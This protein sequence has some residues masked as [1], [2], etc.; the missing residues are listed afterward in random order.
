MVK[1]WPIF[2]MTSRP[3]N[4]VLLLR[5]VP[6]DANVTGQNAINRPLL[7]CLDLVIGEQHVCDERLGWPAEQM[8]VNSLP[9]EDIRDIEPGLEPAP[10]DQDS[11]VLI[12]WQL[13]LK[14][15]KSG[16]TPAKFYIWMLHDCSIRPN[17]RIGSN[18]KSTIKSIQ[19]WRVNFV[20]HK[21]IA[22][23]KIEMCG[24]VPLK[25]V[26][27]HKHTQFGTSL[28]FPEHTCMC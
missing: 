5:R 25:I 23:M 15:S 27:I 14:I 18:I 9:E 19:T 24:A 11:S 8:W 10:S 22:H 13:R 21:Y 26:L 4:T 17:W 20:W 7:K 3:S 6:R 28:I 12:T 16:R 2:P 1:S